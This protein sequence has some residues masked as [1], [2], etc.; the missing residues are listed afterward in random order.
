MRWAFEHGFHLMNSTE[1]N[2]T[3]HNKSCNAIQTFG[4]KNS[5]N[6]ALYL[7]KSDFGPLLVKLPHKYEYVVHLLPY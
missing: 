7:H 2:E 4:I 1:F 6:A 5:Y 3:F